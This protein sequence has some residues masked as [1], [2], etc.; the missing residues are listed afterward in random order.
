M[1]SHYREAK[2]AND[3]GDDN[4]TEEQKAVQRLSDDEDDANA[5]ITFKDFIVLNQIK[6]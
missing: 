5:E 3:I 6:G 2:T 4:E 1:Y